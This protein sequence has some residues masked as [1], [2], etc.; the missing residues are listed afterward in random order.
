MITQYQH[1]VYVSMG[2]FLVSHTSVLTIIPF[3]N[4]P[5]R[6]RTCQ[7]TVGLTSTCL[8]IGVNDHP[9]TLGV[10]CAQYIASP[11]HCW[12]FGPLQ[13]KSWKVCMML[14]WHQSQTLTKNFFPIGDQT[15]S[16]S[17]STNSKQYIL[18][19]MTLRSGHF[20]F[21]CIEIC[22]WSDI[23]WLRRSKRQVSDCYFETGP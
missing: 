15:T 21:L 4:I 18:N 16:T 12:L 14:G 7:L 1:C 9:T 17:C 2:T 11:S 23:Q 22:N 19:L 6:T 20:K 5:L 3:C 10:M 13:I 8:L